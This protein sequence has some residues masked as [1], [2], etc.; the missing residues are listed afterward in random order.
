MQHYRHQPSPDDL[1]ISG[2]D[3]DDQSSNA[4]SDAMNPNGASSNEEE[5][6]DTWLADPPVGELSCDFAAS[7]WPAGLYNI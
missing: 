6:A 1:E 5:D 2:S 7:N 3:Q 4:S